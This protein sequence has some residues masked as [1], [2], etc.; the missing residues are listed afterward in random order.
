MTFFVFVLDTTLLNLVELIF[1]RINIVLNKQIKNK[2][3]KRMKNTSIEFP[4]YYIDVWF[5]RLD[6]ARTVS[7]YTRQSRTP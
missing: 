3:K 5:N 7:A 4:W 2:N 1:K 6:N